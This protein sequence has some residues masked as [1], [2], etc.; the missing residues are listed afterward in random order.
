M[1]EV[2]YSKLET[3]LLSSGDPVEGDTAVSNPREVRP[4]YTLKE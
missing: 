2:R 3:G 1:S 4:F